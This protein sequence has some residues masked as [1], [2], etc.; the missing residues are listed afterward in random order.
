MTNLELLLKE[1]ALPSGKFATTALMMSCAGLMTYNLVRVMVQVGLLDKKKA[2]RAKL[3]RR[4]KIVL[5]NLMY[6]AI[7]LILHGY[8]LTSHF[9]YHA[10]QQAP[11]F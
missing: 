3:R 4:L 1:E 2:H 7:R 8:G 11:A 6:F 9:S 5:Q 10:T